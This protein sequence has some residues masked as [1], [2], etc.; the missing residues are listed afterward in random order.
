MGSTAAAPPSDFSAAT[1]MYLNPEVVAFS[2]VTTV[3]AAYDRYASEFSHLPYAVPPPAFQGPF[4]ADMYV[5]QHRA[6]LDVSALNH[7]IQLADIAS[8]GL[9]SNTA[10]S[11]GVPGRYV[12]NLYVAA[13]LVAEDT[14]RIVQPTAPNAPHYAL[15][16]C[17][18]RVGDDVK[19]LAGQGREL[20]F[21]EVTEL[22]SNGQ[23]LR[24]AAR[25]AA[26][27]VTDSNVAY[28]LFGIR[29][30]DLERIAHINYTR[31]YLAGFSNEAPTPP[32]TGDA[33]GGAHGFNPELY[34]VLYPDARF[35][36][37][38]EAFVSSRDNWVST[39]APRITNAD[40]ILTTTGAVVDALRVT[41][42]LDLPPGTALTLDGTTVYSISTDDSTPSSNLRHPS[43]DALITESAIK[44]YVERPYHTTA[45]FNDVDV[46]GALRVAGDLDM[47]G[48]TLGADSVKTQSLEVA[49]NL[50][51]DA[52][53]VR[54]LATDL[55]C[56]CNIAC[57]GAAAAS[58]VYA[59]A[60]IG[61]GGL[62]D[63]AS[64]TSGW[65]AASSS[66]NA[67]SAQD[68]QALALRV[69]DRIVLGP[70]GEDWTLETSPGALN[71]RS[72][73][74]SGSSDPLM[75]LRG[76]QRSV[77]LEGD[78]YVRGNY[79]TLSDARAKRDVEPIRDALA[80][81]R[82]LRA[83][84]YSL[85]DSVGSVARCTGRRHLGVL[86]DE[87][88][89]VV[90]EAV[91]SAP[92]SSE[93]SVEYGGLCALLL[94]AVNELASMVEEIRAAQRLSMA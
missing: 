12:T 80:R 88:Q 15:G 23:T 13:E 71:I 41:S 74:T 86:A 22:G 64:P 49:S 92:G 36:T 43:N 34:R 21:G 29:V 58:A 16:A 61:V 72:S 30:R 89:T 20:V 26:S 31:R 48:G 45:T 77:L 66:S 10:K 82:A 11:G 25:D 85:H 56:D 1:F 69:L 83:C 93:K 3:E 5:A 14:F 67:T 73:S 65:P 57:T 79:L 47:R 68:R 91:S 75:Q 90:P 53:N 40:E 32:L 8:T 28:T 51:A 2:N 19:I 38:E 94:Q 55:R 60:R 63:D 46:L 59:G 54:V 62:R 6:V 27:P 7:V 52:S 9:T 81:V 78:V 42:N 18:V 44:R 84:S 17:N 76:D 4:V 39:V 33:G 50:Y 24:I 87:V 35:L 37:Q 70:D